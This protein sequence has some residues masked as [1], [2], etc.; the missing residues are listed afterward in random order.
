MIKLLQT[1][2]Y[3]MENK[4]FSTSSWGN[5]SN[6]NPSPSGKWKFGGRRRYLSVHVH[7]KHFK[8][9][10]TTFCR[11]TCIIITF[12]QIKKKYSE[13]VVFFFFQQWFCFYSVMQFIQNVKNTASTPFFACWDLDP[14]P[15]GI[16]YPQSYKIF[17]CGDG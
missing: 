6:A 3:M 13:I 7:Y 2:F 17:L 15:K 12:S 5:T 9:R 14:C 4:Y 1:S 11:K 8:A 16:F 10:H